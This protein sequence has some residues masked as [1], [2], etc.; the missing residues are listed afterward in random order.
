MQTPGRQG[1]QKVVGAPTARMPLGAHW[2]QGSRLRDDGWA[3]P[4]SPALTL[5]LDGVFD[6]VRIW[7]WGLIP[8]A[9]SSSPCA[10]APRAP[11]A[12]PGASQ[13]PGPA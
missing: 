10:Q 6:P 8:S 2:V 1:P 7:G 12:D 9:F 3:R 5:I 11:P 13:Q 4:A